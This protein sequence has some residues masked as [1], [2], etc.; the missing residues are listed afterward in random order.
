MGQ[1][2]MRLGDMTVGHGFPPTPTI[3]ASTNV[4]A[5]GKGVVRQGDTYKL[6]CMSG[7]CH[8]PNAAKVSSTVKVNGKGVHRTGDK[9]SC[10]DTAGQGSPTVKAGG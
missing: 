8:Q 4:F 1:S 5:N 7:S 10:G 2:V 3:K 6:H 9:T